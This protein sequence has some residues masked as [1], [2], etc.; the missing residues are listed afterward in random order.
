MGTKYAS[1]AGKTT[2]SAFVVCAFG[3]IKPNVIGYACSSFITES[4]TTN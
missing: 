3:Y 1:H 4:E 2:T